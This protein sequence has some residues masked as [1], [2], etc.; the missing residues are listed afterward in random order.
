MKYLFFLVLILPAC[1]SVSVQKMAKASPKSSGCHLDVFTDKAEI[2][3]KY[4]TACLITS[5]TATNIFANRTPEAALENAKEQACE[6]GA[7]AVLIDQY[8]A[9]GGGLFGAKS[10]AVSFKAIVRRN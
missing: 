2:S 4:E 9:E 5:T 7:D 8:S 1:A 6:C 10:G 3:G